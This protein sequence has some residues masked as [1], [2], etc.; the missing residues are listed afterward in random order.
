MITFS[1]RHISIILCKKMIKLSRDSR[2]IFR[3]MTFMYVQA[4]KFN[5]RK[6]NIFYAS[7]FEKFICGWRA[8]H[9]VSKRTTMSFF[10]HFGF[11][12]MPIFVFIM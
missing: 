8:Y 4:V 7:L 3:P 2:G 6:I 11:Y 10:I 12:D 5:F 9:V 1:V